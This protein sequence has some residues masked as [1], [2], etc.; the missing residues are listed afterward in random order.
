LSPY[1][2][3]ILRNVEAKVLPYSV[4][5]LLIVAGLT[6][7]FFVFPQSDM[8]VHADPVIMDFIYF[9]TIS[10]DHTQVPANLVNFPVLINITDTDLRDNCLSSG[11]D[12]AFFNATYVQLNHEIELW[13]NTTGQLV[14]WVN[15]TSL[16]STADTII[17]MAY[18]DSDIASSA[19]SV[20]DTWDSNYVAVYHMNDSTTSTIKDSTVNNNDGTK[21][22]TNEPNEVD[23]KI[24]K[25]QDFD[26]SDD[27]IVVPDSD[28]FDYSLNKTVTLFFKPDAIESN[29]KKI[30]FVG[31]SATLKTGIWMMQSSGDGYY[32]IDFYNGTVQN[33]ILGPL[34]L[35][36]NVYTQLGFIW[37]ED[38]HE[39]QTITNGVLGSIAT[40]DGQSPVKGGMWFGCWYNLADKVDGEIDECRISNGV[41]SAEWIEAEYN[42]VCNAYDG[43]FFAL[44]TTTF[45]RYNA[46]DTTFSFSALPGSTIWSTGNNT[47]EITTAMASEN[48][49]CENIYLYFE[50]IDIDFTRENISFAIINTTDGSW[51]SITSTLQVSADGNMSINATTWAAGIAAGWA[52][53][54]NPFPIEDYDSLLAVRIN[55]NIPAGKAAG[56][57]S[58]S[59][60][61]VL[62]KVV[63]G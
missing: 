34:C 38:G 50:D 48:G 58:T 2:K 32:T 7:M 49:Y 45:V 14:A 43:G 57:Y 21:K 42:T 37:N 19:E 10:F 46:K 11:W 4:L 28:Q 60:C 51:A 27:Y 61:K 12:I 55:V 15:V 33:E 40:A 63:L 8:I 29:F 36:N 39:W 3:K 54:T 22:A 30:L 24:G 52:S 13:D 25:A 9:K 1:T 59:D 16:S 35:T 47:M 56:S 20:E 41:R 53:G 17:Y 23:G 5:I 26:G 31:G 18:G 6:T 62:W 44:G